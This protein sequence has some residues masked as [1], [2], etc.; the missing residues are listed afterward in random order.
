MPHHLTRIGCPEGNRLRLQCFSPFPSTNHLLI[1]TSMDRKLLLAMLLAGLLLSVP[2]V[3]GDEEDY[4][5]DSEEAADEKKDSDDE[6][7]VKVLTTKNWD[8]TVGKAKYALVRL[9]LAHI[10]ARSAS[11]RLNYL[12]HHC[13]PY[14]SLSRP[15]CRFPP[16]LG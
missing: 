12:H 5:D 13:S 4:E 6:P 10:A 15:L 11:N 8:E 9:S 3:R 14:V 16:S 7:H 2:F 1:S